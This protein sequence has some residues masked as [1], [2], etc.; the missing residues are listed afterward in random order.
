MTGAT[1]HTVLRQP[2]CVFCLHPSVMRDGRVSIATAFGLSYSGILTGAIAKG[3]GR[4]LGTSVV[5]IKGGDV[6]DGDVGR[7]GRRA[8]AS[9]TNGSLTGTGGGS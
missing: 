1:H 4:D 9:S 6:D 7:G 3:A 8:T 5:S 2:P